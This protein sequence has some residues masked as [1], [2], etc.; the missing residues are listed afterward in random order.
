MAYQYLVREKI[1]RDRQSIPEDF[2]HERELIMNH[3]D[4]SRADFI[5]G[6]HRSLPAFTS[7]HSFS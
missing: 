3:S 2:L 4:E 7:S 6:T 1:N 5:P